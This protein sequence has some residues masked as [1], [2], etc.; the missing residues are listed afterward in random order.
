[1]PWTFAHPAAVLPLRRLCPA[2]LSFTG[3]VLGSLM[4]DLGY[5]FGR[6]DLASF[7]HTPWGVLMVC[8]PAGLVLLVLARP[9]YRPVV[10]LLPQPHRGALL[11]LGRPRTVFS[12]RMFGVAAISLLIGAFSHTAWDAFTH[13]NGYFVAYLPPLQAPLF[14]LGNHVVY[15]YHILQHTSTVV[16]IVLLTIAYLRVLRLTRADTGVTG[17]REWPRYA[18]FAVLALVSPACA[19]SFAYADAAPSGSEPNME[20]LMLRMIVYTTTAFI[21]LF[22]AAAVGLA[23]RRRWVAG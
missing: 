14:Q 22:G 15:V 2:Y 20:V 23:Y 4:P 7:A 18:F 3:L 10:H 11:A 19:W 8:L 9:L 1:M 6:F 13:N 12:F 16:G 21:A 5:Y 17:T